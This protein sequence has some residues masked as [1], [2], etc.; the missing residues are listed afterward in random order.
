MQMIKSRLGLVLNAIGLE[1]SA[2]FLSQSQSKLW[3]NESKPQLLST[4]NSKFHEEHGSS[5]DNKKGIRVFDPCLC[6]SAMR[7]FPLAPYDSLIFIQATQVDPFP[8]GVTLKCFDKISFL[9]FESSNLFIRAARLPT[10]IHRIIPARELGA[11]LD[12]GRGKA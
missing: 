2:S 5:W 11:I 10:R 7:I 9:S 6:S 8:T 1:R 4:L 12:P 3:L